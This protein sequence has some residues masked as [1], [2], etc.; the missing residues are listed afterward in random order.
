M[1]VCDAQ[2]DAGVQVT[3]C[4][5]GQKGGWVGRA[6]R[7]EADGRSA[8]FNQN[9]DRRSPAFA[10]LVAS[11]KRGCHCFGVRYGSEGELMVNT[12]RTT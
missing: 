1:E 2:D 6:S 3:G 12:A 10:G 5:G 8:F 11:V 4:V 9:H 7:N